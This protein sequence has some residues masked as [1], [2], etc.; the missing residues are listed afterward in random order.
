MSELVTHEFKSSLIQLNSN[1]W[2]LCFLV[3][4]EVVNY[5]KEKEVT[6][7]LFR[8]NDS[9]EYPRALI[10]TG[11]GRYYIYLNKEIAKKQQL[12]VGSEH[13]ISLRADESKYGMPMPEELSEAFV[14]FPLADEY[15]HK[16][17]PGKQRTLIYQV[18]KPKREETRVR[19]AVQILEYL[20]HVQGKL[21]FK[22]LNQWFK[23]HPGY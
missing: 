14:L 5:F 10:S 12:I 13:L 8:I 4:Q 1:V 9:E 7:F 2:G 6:R 23:N 19:K 17:T 3:P 21:D 11:E 16:L 15:F 22:E 18:A 20:E